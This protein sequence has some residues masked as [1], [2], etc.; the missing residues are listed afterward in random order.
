MENF[1]TFNEEYIMRKMGLN[2]QS[3]K[4]KIYAK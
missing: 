2:F 4:S 1:V 3:N